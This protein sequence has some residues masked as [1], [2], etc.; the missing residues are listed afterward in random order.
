MKNSLFHF[1]LRI[2]GLFFGL[3]AIWG[4]VIFVFNI[5]NVSLSS[6]YAIPLFA[7][8]TL[9][10]STSKIVDLLENISERMNNL[11]KDDPSNEN[12]QK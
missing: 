5:P 8:A 4:F 2:S 10:F 6:T 11:E 3:A 12:E 1:I 7:L 9:L